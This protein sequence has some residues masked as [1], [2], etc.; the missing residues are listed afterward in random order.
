M[1]ELDARGLIAQ[2]KG[3]GRIA[4]DEAAAT[5]SIFGFSYSF[6]KADHA[7]VAEVVR[8]AYPGFEVTWS[9]EGY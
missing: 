2:M 4:L 9:D 6:G 7:S 5:V 3:G 8:G 1:E